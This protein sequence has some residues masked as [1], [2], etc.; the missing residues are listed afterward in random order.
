M[1]LSLFVVLLGLSAVALGL[2]Y[3]T[4]DSHYAFVGLTFLFLLGIVVVTGELEVESG[5]TINESVT[6]IT[7]VE[8]DYT[9]Y[10]GTT[11]RW[12]GLFLSFASFA[13]ASLMF[14]DFRKKKQEAG[15]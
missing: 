9:S 5:V 6:N 13:G 10:T 1:I 14:I 12:F 3:F 2:G 8:Y 11:S 7:V 15:E 4:G